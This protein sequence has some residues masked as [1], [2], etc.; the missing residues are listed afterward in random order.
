MRN[1]IGYLALSL[2]AAAFAGCSSTDTN[3][4]SS[5]GSESNSG[6]LGRYLSQVIPLANPCTFVVSTGIATVSVE[7]VKDTLVVLSKRLVDSALLVNGLTCVEASSNTAAAGT[8]LKSIVVQP[9]AATDLDGTA[10]TVLIDTRNGL[11][12][13]KS[14]ATGGIKINLGATGDGDEVAI[15]SA[16][17]NET[18]GCAYDATIKDQIGLKTATSADVTFTNAAKAIDKVTVDLSDGNDTFDK[19]ACT[20]AFTVYG[21]AG[22][23]TINAGT[24]STGDDTFSGGTGTDVL[25]YTGRGASTSVVVNLTAASV[26]TATTPAS[27]FTRASLT[28]GVSGETDTLVDDFETI[29]TGAGTDVIFSGSALSAYTLNGGLGNDRFV[30]VKDHPATMTGGGGTDTVDYSGRASKVTATMADSLANDGEATSTLKDNIGKDIANYMASANGDAVTGNT[31]DNIFIGGAGADTFS[32][33]DGADT[34]L[35]SAADD[36]DD[37]FNG[38]NGS[39]TIDYSKRGA[40]VCVTIDGH[41]SSGSCTLTKAVVSPWMSA[42]AP[43]TGDLDTLG[44]DVENVIGTT[45][46]DKIVGSSADNVIFGMGGDD[47]LIGGAGNDSIDA[48]KYVD[49]SANVCNPVTWAC[50]NSAAAGCACT[51]TLTVTCTAALVASTAVEDDGNGNICDPGDLTACLNTLADAAAGCDCSTAAAAT[52]ALTVV[53]DLGNICDTSAATYT[54]TN[55]ALLTTAGLTCDCGDPTKVSTVNPPARTGT[56]VNCGGNPLDVVT[57]HG[58]T[59]TTKMADPTKVWTAAGT[60]CWKVQAN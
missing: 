55:Q 14:G 49:A 36:G 20:T 56:D 54:C 17:G 47:W 52:T 59:N 29:T 53:D 16:T 5:A 19:A 31:L 35:A 48:N 33:S 60:G 7:E 42:T 57:C 51:A 24:A 25:T 58:V 12:A 10:Q 2:L 38:G 18:M 45:H 1:P 28:A 22:N 40:G 4:T 3:P 43:V 46:D 26:T 34:F 32:G 9:K 30:T 50:V 15:L 8:A 6:P 44:T 23:D 37:I 21:G 39:D 11:F 27:P 41:A 13:L